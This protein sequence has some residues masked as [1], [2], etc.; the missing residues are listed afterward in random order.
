MDRHRVQHLSS[1]LAPQT[2]QTSGGGRSSAGRARRRARSGTGT[3]RSAPGERQHRPQVT[4][5][6]RL[7][8]PSRHSHDDSA[9]RA[10]PGARAAFAGRSRR[11][12]LRTCRR[13]GR[14]VHGG[15]R[16]VPARAAE[17]VAAARGRDA[18]ALRRP[19]SLGDL[20]E[21]RPRPS[22]AARRSISCSRGSSRT[23][24][25]GSIGSAALLGALRRRE[26]PG[27]R[28][29]RAHGSPAGRRRS[30]DR[31]RRR[32]AGCSSSTASTGGCTASSSSRAR[33]RTS[34][35]CG[36]VERRRPAALGALGARDARDGRDAPL[37]GA[38]AR[39]A[40]R[41][42]C[43]RAARTRPAIV[44]FAAVARARDPV[45]AH[46][47]RARRRGST[48]ASAAAGRSSAGRVA[49]S[50]P[51][52]VAGDFTAGLDAGCAR[53]RPRRVV[54]AR[55]LLARGT[56]PRRSS[57]PCVVRDADAAFVAR[58]ARPV[59]LARV[60]PSDLRAAVLRA[61]RRARAVDLTR[62]RTRGACARRGVVLA[63]E[64]GGR[65]GLGQDALR[66]IEGEPAARVE[67]REAASA[68]LARTTR[69]RRHPVRLRPAL[70]RRLG[71]RPRS[72]PG[73][74]V[75]PVPTRSSR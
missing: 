59:D 63:D 19:Q 10:A 53:P 62:R 4:A 39:L 8:S 46:R 41:C 75:S 3:R 30:R 9:G 13:R 1:G 28:A 11:A 17:R 32:R 73:H 67:A 5:R 43:S 57:P 20:F 40:G 47:P 55:A 15:R 54:G 58:A 49:C 31:A 14:R 29:P 35:S 6:R 51:P 16:R 72:V 12:R 60:A 27:H 45:L 48:S 2:S 21:H 22:A 71:A 66:S 24:A 34:R 65:L 25:A 56:A 74:V 33:C 69:P 36:A 61:A 7:R 23:S 68:W 50:L 38:R 18:R 26:R 70:P 42:T 44:A 52:P 64:R 37:R